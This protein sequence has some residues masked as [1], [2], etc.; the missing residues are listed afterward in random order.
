MSNK[1][2]VKAR[3]TII[4]LYSR[5]LAL[6]WVLL[7]GGLAVWL[8]PTAWNFS[9]QL[10][11]TLTGVDDSPAETVRVALTKNFT[12]ALAFPTAIIWDSRGLSEDT[13]SVVWGRIM[14]SA[15]QAPGVTQVY[16]GKSL[17]G[18]WPR[19]DWHAGFVEL[20]ADDYGEAEKLIPGLRKQ[21][22]TDAVAP[23]EHP[24]W[25][26]G[27]PALFFDL[28][29]AST[30]GLRDAELMALPVTFIIL[31]LVFR[32]AVAAVLPVL[33]AGLG[34][35]V[36]L[37][38]LSFTS[39][40]WPMTFFV[41]NL[42]TMIGLGVGIDYSLIYLARYRRERAQ[43][44]TVI[45]SLEVT[46][47]TAGHT[48]V[49]SAALVMTGFVAL[50]VIPIQFFHSI[51]LGGILVVGTVAGATLT[52]MPSAIFLMGRSLEY[53][54]VFNS[55]RRVAQKVRQTYQ[56]WTRLLL[57]YP[58]YFFLAGMSALVLVAL[59]INHLLVTSLQASTL[60]PHSESRLGY[61]SLQ[62]ELG[63]GWL[64][65]T[66]VLAQHGTEGA[67]MGPEMLAQEK[68]L[69][70]RIKRLENTDRVISLAAPPEDSSQRREQAGLL[71]GSPESGQT[72]LLAISREDPQSPTG[73]L[74]LH[75]LQRVLHEQEESYPQGAK[76]LVGGVAATTTA[77]DEVIFA[78]LPKVIMLTL[79]TTF[80]LLIYYMQSILVP[81][82][83]I[84]LNLFCVLA[85]YGFQVLWFQQG[86]GHCISSIF[87]HT[88]GLNTIVLVICFCALFGL[89]M[90]Y[91]VFILSA[92]RECWLDQRNFKIAIE[93]GLEK[94][95][96][97]ITSAALIM[98]S[99]FLCF[100]FGSVVET[101]QIGMGL[102][103][104]V[105]LDAT[106]VRLILAPSALALMGKWAWWMPG[107]PMPGSAR[108]RD[109]RPLE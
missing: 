52:F 58:E 6:A 109:H 98:V 43:H 101:Q 37:G 64:M 1:F 32:S 55:N 35:V 29:I 15:K 31:L 90:D 23:K 50:V 51:A 53:G 59:P 100:A 107:H 60:P 30:E 93:D 17:L 68:E 47:N 34:V 22:L 106:L 2:F 10:K 85:A 88:D 63:Q 108:K 13:A 97:I 99:V 19:P 74:W 38:I 21:V 18:G 66:I 82:K 86:V 26:T 57:Y 75:Q 91:E 5:R 104:A 62:K 27:G 103:F 95:S 36:T 77:T 41:P 42:V 16:D 8:G 54:R 11:G 46:R 40:I 33:V 102:S 48:I 71:T 84:I 3:Q 20:K 24:T 4:R 67:E 78:A 70:A 81:L 25:I 12:T 45:E 9:H 61:E 65:P 92:V 56:I 39:T 14:Q 72:I 49:C 7:W 96:G 80:F 76:Y 87:P 79:V 94:T 105:M 44:L 69:V 89:S 83:A 28:N 73:R